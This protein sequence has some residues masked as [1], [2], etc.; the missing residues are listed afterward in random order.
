MLP[1]F[2]YTANSQCASR[3]L[4]C[5]RG[6]NRLQSNKA[7]NDT[8]RP[9]PS[10]NVLGL[11]DVW[12][13]SRCA[14]TS[15]SIKLL[16]GSCAWALVFVGHLINGCGVDPEF[17]EATSELL[18]ISTS[19]F[20]WHL[21]FIGSLASLQSVIHPQHLREHSL[22]DRFLARDWVFIWDCKLLNIPSDAQVILHCLPNSPESSRQF[23]SRKCRVWGFP[24]I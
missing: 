11:C 21:S 16:S 24:P 4:Q 15:W 12:C 6:C 10:H 18:F 5:H 8:R 7:L 23:K 1:V 3:Q 20:C 14:S 22:S 19:D 13:A 9:W 17:L 2:F